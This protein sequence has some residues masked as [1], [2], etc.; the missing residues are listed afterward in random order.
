MV[1]GRLFR[2]TELR[3]DGYADVAILNEAAV[4][5]LFPGESALDRRFAIESSPERYYRVVGIVQ[6]GVPSKCST[7]DPIVHREQFW[8]VVEGK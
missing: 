5:L 3:E 7:Y 8:R 4:K 6:D 1:A 2:D